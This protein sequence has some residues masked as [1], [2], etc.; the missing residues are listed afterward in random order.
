MVAVFPMVGRISAIDYIT[1]QLK[2][3]SAALSQ[4][5]STYRLGRNFLSSAATRLDLFIREPGDDANLFM[6]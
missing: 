6:T 2:C 5:C 1:Y 3:A 4:A